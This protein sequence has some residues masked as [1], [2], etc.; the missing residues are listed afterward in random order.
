MKN[1]SFLIMA[2]L[3]MNESFTKNDN[4]I[5]EGIVKETDIKT[6][7]YELIQKTKDCELY[8][9]LE[10]SKSN[11]EV[12]TKRCKVISGKKIMY[13][14][15]I[16]LSA[17]VIG[18]LIGVVIL[19]TSTTRTDGSWESWQMW[20]SCSNDCGGGFRTRSRTCSNPTPSPLGRYCQGNSIG[21]ESCENEN[22]DGSWENWL[23]WSNCSA[24]CGAG[25]R[26]RSRTCSNT[27]LSPFGRYRQGNSIDIE[28]CENQNCDVCQSRPCH[29]GI[30]IS[31]GDDFD[32]VCLSGYTG[33]FCEN[34]L[35][36]CFDILRYGGNRKDGVYTLRTWKSHQLIKV[37]CDMTTDGGGWAVFQYRFNGSVDFY[38]K[39]SE[40]EQGFGNL[41]TEFWLG[42]MYIEEL[43]SQGR[44]DLR[45]DLEA[46]D[47]KTGFEKFDN[48][49]LSAGPAY[50]L[51]IGTT[52]ASS[53]IFSVYSFGPFHNGMNFTTYDHDADFNKDDNCARVFHG[54]WWY[55]NCYMANLNGEYISPGTYTARS[56]TYRSFL[57]LD[58][59]SL[60]S[61]KM[62]MKRN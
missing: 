1:K 8:Q 17:S 6:D 52:I 36:D 14:F 35:S 53:G 55:N 61:S 50:T 56:M 38:R 44:T 26:T 62:M 9:T 41:K 42:L 32:C 4:I 37:Y 25:F 30:C 40:Y 59:T 11:Q 29:A 3:Y 15:L 28:S 20:S 5:E 23:M 48:F 60:K 2:A 57:G 34:M 19:F 31:K 46:P 49:S 22:C 51:H 47:G 16:F 7:V 58:F 45:I 43:A 54:A 12:D 18:T 33:R 39:F 24:D 10:K 13:M 27:T 21:I